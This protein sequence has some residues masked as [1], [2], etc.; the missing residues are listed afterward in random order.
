MWHFLPSVPKGL[1]KWPWHPDGW[2]NVL[3]A[4][5][6]S[7]WGAKGWGWAYKGKVST[8]QRVRQRRIRQGTRQ[9]GDT[10][11]HPTPCFLGTSNLWLVRCPRPRTVPVLPR[12]DY[13]GPRW[14]LFSSTQKKK[15]FLKTGSWGWDCSSVVECWWIMPDSLGLVPAVCLQF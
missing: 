13:Q 12:N 9:S 4:F 11:P 6:G 8:M 15:I 14:P 3:S 1:L 5:W 7:F 10:L 2:K